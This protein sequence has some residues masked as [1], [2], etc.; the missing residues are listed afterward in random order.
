[1]KKAFPIIVALFIV[2]FV[3]ALYVVASAKELTLKAGDVVYACNC[4][5]GCDCGTLSSSPGKCVCGKDLVQTKVMGVGGGKAILLAEGWQKDRIFS[6]VG[7]YAC[8]CGP[9]CKCNTISQKPGKC[10][11]GAE[12]TEQ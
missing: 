9:A 6:T 7:K 12:M 5:P 10:V 8:N 4:G 1:M 2:F 3:I 11:C